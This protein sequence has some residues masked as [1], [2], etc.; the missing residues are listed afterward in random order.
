V[1]PVL[2]LEL[3]LRAEPY[4]E[5]VRLTVDSFVACGALAGLG[6]PDLRERFV[7]VIRCP[8]DLVFYVHCG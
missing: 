3:L 1:L 8:A 6:Y 7:Q 4:Q 5:L 2:L